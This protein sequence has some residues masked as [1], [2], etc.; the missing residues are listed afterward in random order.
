M[1]EPTNSDRFGVFHGTVGFM[2][3][4]GKGGP[5]T[6]GIGPGHDGSLVVGRFKFR[7]PLAH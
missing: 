3:N 1:F 5:Q 6:G 4:A 7:L 2:P